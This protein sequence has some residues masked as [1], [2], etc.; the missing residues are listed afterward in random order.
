MRALRNLF[1]LA[2]IVVVLGGGALAAFRVA[3]TR[4]SNP[5]EIKA[6]VMAVSSAGAYLYAARVGQ[7]V[8]LFDTGADPGGS[9]ADT[10][11]SAL[12][13]GRGDVTDVFL[14]HG[15]GDHI[16]AAGDFAGAHIHLGEGDVAF[17]E[18]R[19]PWDNLVLRVMARGMGV[20]S[21]SVSSPLNGVQAIDLGGG[22][23]VKAIPVPGHTPGSYVFLY[24]DV[25]YT[26]DTALFKQGRLERGPGL[27]DSNADQVKASVTALKQQLTGVEVAAVCTGHGGCTP[28]GLG[29]T[30]LDDF[31]GRVGG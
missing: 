18:G 9:P 30:L 12:H 27:F 5:E 31:I 16:A 20:P 3:R 28:L 15:H 14:T 6:G 2:I 11:L 7:H 22:K 19:A 29:R 8:V 26:G 17:V 24:D 1:A 21:V 4:P 13:A 10:A 23:T 25:L